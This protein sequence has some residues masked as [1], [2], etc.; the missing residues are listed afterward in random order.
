MCISKSSVGFLLILDMVKTLSHRQVFLVVLDGLLVV[1]Q[2][3]VAVRQ[4]PVGPPSVQH[5]LAST[6][7]LQHGQL[8]L[9][10]SDSF[11]KHRHVHLGDAHVSVDLGLQTG[12]SEP[13][14]QP[15]LAFVALEGCGVVP[16]CHMDCC[17]VA[18]GPALPLG[19][20]Q[21]LTESQL[22]AVEGQGGVQLAKKPS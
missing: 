22:L 14:R 7:L 21:V 6:Q 3:V 4:A 17:Q 11:L 10:V 20:G 9:K 15:Q 12:V 16:L 5:S 8:L 1:S 18:Q 13:L 2:S 19:V